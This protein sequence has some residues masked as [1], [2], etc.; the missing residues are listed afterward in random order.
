MYNSISLLQINRF[1]SIVHSFVQSFIQYLA[2]PSRTTPV[3]QTTTTVATTET[4]CNG[5][6]STNW[7]C[8]SHTAPCNEG[9]GDC[10]RDSDCIGTLKCGMDN[11]LTDFSSSGSGWNTGADCCAG[12]DINKYTHPPTHIYNIILMYRTILQLRRILFLFSRPYTGMQRYTFN[13]LELLF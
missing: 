10:D 11:C 6:P 8:C 4:T 1:I 3:P 2:R 12:K 9:G 7:T 5:V 13:R